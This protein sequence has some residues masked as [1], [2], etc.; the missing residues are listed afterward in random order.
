MFCFG[1]VCPVFPDLSFPSTVFTVSHY[2]IFS[3]IS[4]RARTAGETERWDVSA[5]VPAPETGTTNTANTAERAEIK[6]TATRSAATAA[7]L[8]SPV[9][10]RGAGTGEGAHLNI[11]GCLSEV[12]CVQHQ[13]L[14]SRPHYWLSLVSVD[15]EF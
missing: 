3:D 13:I 15:L 5:P 4:R 14:T 11:M 6:A 10:K 1:L 2:H 8:R 12:N 9:I 7:P